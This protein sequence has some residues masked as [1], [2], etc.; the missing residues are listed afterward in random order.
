MRKNDATTSSPSWSANARI[1]ERLKFGFE[2]E[3]PKQQ[4][5]ALPFLYLVS[6]RVERGDEI[7]QVF[8]TRKSSI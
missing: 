3:R 6:L 5:T 2:S 1:C 8:D 4:Y 7:W